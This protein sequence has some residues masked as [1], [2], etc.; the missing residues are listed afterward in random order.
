MNACATVGS[1][2]PAFNV[3]GITR[4]GTILKNLKTAVLVANEPIPS[5]SKKLVTNPRPIIGGVGKRASVAGNGSRPDRRRTAD[6][7]R[8]H[9]AM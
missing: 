4:S 1:V 6:T 2:W 7:A 8:A 3:P 5:A 9:P